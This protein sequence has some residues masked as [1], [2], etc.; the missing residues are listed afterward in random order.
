MI[1]YT[2]SY[3]EAYKLRSTLKELGIKAKV[4]KK[5]WNDLYH[6]IS[7]DPVSPTITKDYVRDICRELNLLGI[8][9][10]GG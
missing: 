3:T 5:P 6:K 8:F 1:F 4:G 7:V 2:E 9:H 10:I